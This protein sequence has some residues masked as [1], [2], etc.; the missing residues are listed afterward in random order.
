MDSNYDRQN[1]AKKLLI[2]KGKSVEDQRINRRQVVQPLL[3]LVIHPKFQR[4]VERFK[5]LRIE[6]IDRFRKLKDNDITYD[7]LI[8]L[9]KLLSTLNS[10]DIVEP[11]EMCEFLEDLEKEMNVLEY[12]QYEKRCQEEID[13]ITNTLMNKCDICENLITEKSVCDSCVQEFASQL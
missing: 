10:K 3:N 11:Q 8:E 7:H 4:L 12:E 2:G 13:S 5:S 1:S 6:A 9:K